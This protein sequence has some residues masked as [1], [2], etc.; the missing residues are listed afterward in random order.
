MVVSKVQDDE[1]NSKGNKGN[2][3]HDMKQMGL[4]HLERPPLKYVMWLYDLFNKIEQRDPPPNNPIKTKHLRLI[5]I[6]V[7]HYNEK[8]RWAFDL[9]EE[10]ETSPYYYTEDTHPPGFQA[11]ESIR[12]SHGKGSVTPM[13]IG[14]GESYH[15]DQV[16]MKSD[17]IVR[18]FC[19]HLYPNDEVKI[20]EDDFNNRLGSAV[21]TFA[22]NQL[23]TDQYFPGL[24][25]MAT[26]PECAAIENVLF[27]YTKNMIRSALRKSL[28]IDENSVA[29]SKS[30]IEEIFATATRTL[31]KQEYLV[32]N[33]F[34]A[35]DLT[36]AA[37][38]SPLSRPPEL[39]IFQ[40]P[41][42]DLPHDI[43]SLSE[44]LRNTKAGQHT[45]KM[46][47]QHRQPNSHSSGSSSVRMVQIKTAGRN[48]VPW[49]AA[50]V[51]VGL[52]AMGAAA[53][54]GVYR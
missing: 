47:R 32:G 6:R 8:V 31:E 40:C 45:L 25:K 16:W 53:I 22:Y 9:L 2:L 10:D 30:T 4:R 15:Q 37:L 38:S 46:Y 17:S 41:D 1:S 35:A 3:V 29:L 33:Q 24:V 26:G 20:M 42:N 34:T 12:A 39:K 14:P 48:R 44:K 27:P 36:F 21:R 52:G 28:Q 50:T 54:R 13:V 23:L 5:T 43:L 19:P 49:I 7:S 11:F 18:E 51:V